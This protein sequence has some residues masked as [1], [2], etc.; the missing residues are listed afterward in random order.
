MTSDD[1]AAPPAR[2]KL[3]YSIFGPMS[4]L[5]LGA[6]V[7]GV[8]APEAFYAA[9]K[10]IVEV[11]TRYFGWLFQ[12]ASLLF[13][14]IC[15]YLALSRHGKIKFG[16][17]DAEPE[18]STYAWVTMSLCAGI[19]TGILFWGIA[20]PITH[21]MKPP[22]VLGIAPKSEAAAM[23]AM[24]TTYIH[25]TF[26]PYAMYGVCGVGIAY[27]SYNMKLPYN[28]SSTL[29]PVFGRHVERAVGAVVDNLCLFA[30]AGGVAAMLGVGT[31]QI[32]SGLEVLHGVPSTKVTW[33]AIIS[34]IVGTYVISSYTGLD[35]GIRFLSDYNTRLFL[36]MMFFVFIFGPTRFI[37]TLGTQSLGH[38]IDQF[39]VRATF[40]SPIDNSDW[41]RWW[42]VYY[43]AIWLA[44]APLIGMFLARLVRGRTI[45]QFMFVN[46]VVV[47]C[48]GMIWFAVFGGAAIHSELAG[49]GVWQ[50]IQDKG[51]E[52]SVFAFLE[53]FPLSKPISWVF[54]LAI[55]ISISTLA[56]SMTSTV[57]A[58]STIAARK[59]ESEP[60]TTIKLFWGLVMSSMAI[61]N[62]LSAGGKISG[63]DATK[64]IATVA[65]FPILF[66]MLLM[67]YCVV[68]V[69][70]QQ[71]RYDLAS[72]FET[73]SQ[74][75]PERLWKQR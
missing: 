52:V 25:W 60:P 39:F 23:F 3:R 18:F 36:G 40:L 45:A 11:A 37:L 17:P 21:F 13:L 63:I 15:V 30:I 41:P 8:V 50:S 69:V 55:Y 4:V 33:I 24:T 70:V 1:P 73:A 38:F 12:L 59:Q 6:I 35:R 14:G 7:T 65:G 16:G 57:A 48:F 72:C 61:I 67:A 29:Y 5:F 68:K 46:L 2:A 32:A 20:E 56:D 26:I 27:A 53:G 28:V 44:N 43:W 66:L 19:A 75:M 31:M 74:T 42:P 49:G 54:L 51:L 10:A 9:E 47:A 22:E 62:L 34:L 64:Q 58:L 71:P